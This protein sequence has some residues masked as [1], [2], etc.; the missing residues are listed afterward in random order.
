ML[1][2]DAAVDHAD[3]HVLAGAVDATDLVP[4]AAGRVEPEER[5]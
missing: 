1:R 5:R 2:P 3:D 4:Q